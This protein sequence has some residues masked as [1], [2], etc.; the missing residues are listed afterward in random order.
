V[1]PRLTLNLGL[2]YEY[3]K[4]PDPTNVNPVLP[5]TANMPNDK[6]NFGPR[7][8]FAYDLKGDGKTSIRGG[9][10]IYYGRIIN[11]T[12]YNALINTGVGIT[13]GQRQVTVTATNAIAPSYPNLISAG[14]L[15][16]PAVQYFASNFANPQIHLRLHPRA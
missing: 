14:A 10:G 9:Y 5:Q 2:R 1:S 11:S 8:G 7:I 15:T 13:Q 6:N 16:T 4:N 3:Q 12:I